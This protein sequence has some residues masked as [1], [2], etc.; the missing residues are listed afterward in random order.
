MIAWRCRQRIR[1]RLA[2]RRDSGARDGGGCDPGRVHLELQRRMAPRVSLSARHELLAQ[3]TLRVM[4]VRD[5]CVPIDGLMTQIIRSAKL[6]DQRVLC[7]LYRQLNPA[8][9]PWPSDAVAGDALSHV[10]GHDGTTILI[11][12]VGAIAVSTC[13]LIICPNFSRSGTP[14]RADRKRCHGS[15]ASPARLWSPRC[16]ARD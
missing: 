11:C 15:T 2:R 6:T 3:P 7:D 14:L 12:E 1:A 5:R 8:D 4:I 10:L 9:P 16:G 13:V